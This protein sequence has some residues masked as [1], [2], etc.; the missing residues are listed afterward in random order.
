LREEHKLEVSEN[1]LFRKIF[2][3][4]THESSEK[5]TILENK[6]PRDL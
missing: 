4:E 5:V 6:K 2:G 1:E 3:P